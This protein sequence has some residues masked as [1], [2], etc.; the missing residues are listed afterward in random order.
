MICNDV[1]AR[2]VAA[3]DV[4][5]SLMFAQPTRAKGIPTGAPTGPWLATKDRIPDPHVLNLRCWVNGE[6]RQNSNSKEMLIGI[7]DLVVNLSRAFELVSGD[8]IM[9]G[10]PAG[11]GLAQDPPSFLTGG[12][13]VRMEISGLGALETPVVDETDR[14][15][16]PL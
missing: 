7:P 6:L 11:C 4:R 12:D 10:T 16:T 9:T 15:R 8:I 2:D 5:L 14:L 13:L 1:T 3:K